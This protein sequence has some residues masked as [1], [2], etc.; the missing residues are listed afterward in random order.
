MISEIGGDDR[1]RNVLCS[2]SAV[3]VGFA[4]DKTSLLASL[5]A[6]LLVGVTPLGDF[7]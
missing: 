7:L 1:C 2:L 5:G 3:V 4:D 6:D